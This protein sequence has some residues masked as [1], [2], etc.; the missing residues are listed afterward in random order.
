MEQNNSIS[1]SNVLERYQNAINYYWDACS[2][3]KKSY[4][5]SRFSI[6]ILSALITLMSSLSSANFIEG[7]E[8]LKISFSVITP[9]L[10]VLLT[11]IGGFAQSFHWGAT[12]RDMVMNAEKLERT[13]DLFLATKPEE[14][15]IKKE[16]DIMHSLVIKE[17]HSFF[18]RVLDSEIKPKEKED[19]EDDTKDDK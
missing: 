8:A 10:A 6:I 3:N 7:N 1:E 11:I 18:Q 12:W 2:H 5:R 19:D 9:L 14:R 17:T 13:R 15:D 16:L 4:K